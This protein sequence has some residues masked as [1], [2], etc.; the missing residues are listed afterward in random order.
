M[1]VA[2]LI[3]VTIDLTITL[4]GVLGFT[5]RGMRDE[6]TTKIAQETADELVAAGIIDA[7]ATQIREDIHELN[8]KLAER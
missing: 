2:I 1:T 3:I 6:A 4:V 5:N 7:I 8:S